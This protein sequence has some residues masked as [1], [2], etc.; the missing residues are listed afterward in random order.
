MYT[1]CVAFGA[2]PLSVEQSLRPY[3]SAC[4]VMQR[5][6]RWPAVHR[7]AREWP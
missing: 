7:F 4:A 5:R 1:A 2:S 3:D 6:E